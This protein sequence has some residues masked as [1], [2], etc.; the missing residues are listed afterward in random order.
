MM[1]LVE[2][3]E[4]VDNLLRWASGR[5]NLN[6]RP[7]IVRVSMGNDGQVALKTTGRVGSRW[8][9]GERVSLVRVGN[10]EDETNLSRIC[11]QCVGS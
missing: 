9:L 1:R 7:R 2:V 5:C 4:F 8:N 10:M 6:E 3:E 11:L